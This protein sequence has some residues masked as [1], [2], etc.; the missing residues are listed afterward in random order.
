M[1]G[2]LDVS[3]RWFFLGG[4]IDILFVFISIFSSMA[5]F[6]MGISHGVQNGDRNYYEMAFS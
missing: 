1:G 6:R 2:W 4:P 3:S 5:V